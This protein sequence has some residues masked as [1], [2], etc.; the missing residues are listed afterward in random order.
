MVMMP[1]EHPLARFDTIDIERL[2]GC[3]IVVSP[4]HS[5]PDGMKAA[6][7]PLMEAGVEFVHAPEGRRATIE[8]YAQVHRLMCLRWLPSR[9]EERCA[10]DMKLVPITGDPLKTTTALWR[11][12]GSRSPSAMAFWRNAALLHRILTSRDAEPAYST[13]KS[14]MERPLAEAN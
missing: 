14:D 3:R 1:Q 8:H 4:G 5:H 12:R 6:L 2:A 9:P 11:R 10:G 13:I 7:L